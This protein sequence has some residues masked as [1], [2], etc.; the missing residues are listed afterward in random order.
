MRIDVALLA[1][2]TPTMP[3]PRPPLGTSGWLRVGVVGWP[4]G[5]PR[6]PWV[7]PGVAITLAPAG[8]GT[9]SPLVIGSLYFFRRKCSWTSTSRVGGGVFAY[10]RSKRPMALA[11]CW[12]RNT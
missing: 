7:D 1:L 2:V 12:P 3:A 8:I 10:F 9:K 6:P 4:G 11:Y 5:P